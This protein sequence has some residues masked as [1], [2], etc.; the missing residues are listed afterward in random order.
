MRALIAGTVAEW[1]RLDVLVNN[2]GAGILATV[3]Q[4]T[5][6]EVRAARPRQLPR[7][8]PRRAGRAPAH[9][10]QGAGHSSTSP[11]SSGSARA[12]PRGL[13][14]VEVR[15][16]GLL[17]GAPDRAPLHRDPRD[18]ML[19][20]APTPSTRPRRTAW[21]S[22]R[23]AGPSRARSTSPGRWCGA[24]PASAPRCPR[25]AGAAPVPR[26]RPRAR[27]RRPPAPPA[28]P[29]RSRALTGA[30]RRQVW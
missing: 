29:A 4:T 28:Q 9:A 6:G 18:V 13:R 27:P 21:G 17:G 3:D 5:S 8:G 10:A 30:T 24:P 20:M 22:R 23:G 11:P 15:A 12:V 19:P 25:S 14:R 1:G 26:E 2:A 7:R 16:G